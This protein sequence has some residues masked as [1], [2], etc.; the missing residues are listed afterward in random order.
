MQFKKTINYLDTVK[1]FVKR[2]LFTFMCQN[3]YFA[4][5]SFKCSLGGISM[6]EEVYATKTKLKTALKS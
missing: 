3:Q 2:Q 4:A 5:C 1:K 6:C